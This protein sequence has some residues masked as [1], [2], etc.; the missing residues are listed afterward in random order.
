MLTLT[1]RPDAD[2][3]PKQ[4]AELQNAVEKYLGRRGISYRGVWVLELTKAGRPHYHLLLWLPRGVTL[5]KPDKQGWWR[6]GLTRIEWARNAVGYLVKYAS[7]AKDDWQAGSA[8]PPGAR[9]FGVRGLADSRPGYTHAMRPFWMRERVGC[10]D[11]VKRLRGGGFLNLSTGECF[12]SPW[13]VVGRARDW[14][15]VEFRLRA[16][17]CADFGKVSG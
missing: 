7:K 10:G 14:G 4:V 8:F 6:H 2:Y 3:E 15:W 5:P 16:E 1:Y 13:E 11:R 12:E 9:L 17:T